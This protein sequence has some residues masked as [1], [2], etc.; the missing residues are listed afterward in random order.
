MSK[1]TDEVIAIEKGFWS[2][3]NDPQYFDDHIAPELRVVRRGRR[4]LI[5][6]R[7]LQRWLQESSIRLLGGDT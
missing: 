7:E 2:R 3:S 4:K 1:A 5:D 6:I